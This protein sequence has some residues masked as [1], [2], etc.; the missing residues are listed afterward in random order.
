[1][2]KSPLLDPA[3]LEG[4]A[5]GDRID[6]ICDEF[7]RKRGESK[8]VDLG[9]LL[10]LCESQHR[11]RLLTEL[12]LI[13]CEIAERNS[14]KLDW[15]RHFEAFPEYADQIEAARFRQ[16]S[17]ES[18]SVE[19]AIEPIGAPLRR[20]DHFELLEKIGT[21]G[22][23]SVWKAWDT[24]LQ[25]YAAIKIP[26]ASFATEDALA[27]FLR[28]GRA[29]ARLRHPAIVPVHA[30]GRAGDLAY[31]VSDYVPGRD[32][33]DYLQNS[34]VTPKQA[35]EMC[36][37]IARALDHAHQ[38]GIIHRDLKPANILL[39]E[40]GKPQITD[41]GLAKC[42]QDEVATTIEGRILGT[43]AYMSPEQARGETSKIDGRSDVFALGV[44]LFEMLTG[45]CPYVGNRSERIFQ[46]LNNT[47]PSA[48][49][50]DRSIPTDLDTI[51]GRAME[52][53]IGRRYS[54]AAALAEDLVRFLQNRPILAR[55]VGV[56]EKA[57]RAARRRPAVAIAVLLAIVA[58]TA[59]AIAGKL[60]AENR[61]ILGMQTVVVRTVPPGA[62]VS[63]VPLHTDT[64][65]PIVDQL[66]RAKGWSPV[67]MDLKAGDY[68]VVAA[69]DDGRFHEVRR[70]VP[71]TIHFPGVFR[72]NRWKKLPDGKV[73]L[74]AIDIPAK[75]VIKGMAYVSQ[76]AMN[77]DPP[78]F[79]MD[80]TEFT[81]S[82]YALSLPHWSAEG[83]PWESLP[84]DCAMTL[85]FDEALAVA[86][87]N[88]KR[89]PIEPEYERAAGSLRISNNVEYDK[90]LAS[91]GPVGSTRWDKTMTDPPI[92]G[93]V[94]NVAE[95]TTSTWNGSAV[96]SVAPI[97]RGTDRF[98]V[99]GGSPRL[100]RGEK[101]LQASDYGR[102]FRVDIGRNFRLSGLGFR[103]V[104]SAIEPYADK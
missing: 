45:Q 89:L 21:G 40:S 7:E 60:S 25:R 88:G 86:E 92:L 98:I 27:R 104:R 93:L 56:A 41:F 79:Y 31:L 102:S 67:E 51:C 29:V 36:L 38:H 42:S 78:S 81:V 6:A 9:D 94:T 32:L 11:P 35:A 52:S 63:F 83:T 100:I 68:L 3:L 28:E 26:H 99:R 47:P 71:S 75:D 49:S 97:A 80:P 20:I 53:E 61:N 58:S 85:R 44:I 14:T 19:S 91:I 1:V 23:A 34:R 55:R 22:S 10:A 24:R 57:I 5:P 50:S 103:C 65:Q 46:L 39:D 87:S 18:R 16:R 30:V 73:L 72:H 43:P 76:D 37:A 62:R 4:L 54:S 74:P 95:W 64:G 77:P 59:A 82:Q 69:L 70:R 101:D 2:K 12:L 90:T 17:L 84:D 33:R 15:N 48:R 96:M 66:M 8:S 13:E